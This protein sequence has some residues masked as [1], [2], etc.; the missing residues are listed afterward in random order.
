V[1]GAAECAL[2]SAPAST[3][4]VAHALIALEAGV[5]T[6]PLAL[7]PWDGTK[8]P[9]PAWEKPQSLDS[10]MKSSVLWFYRRTA[11][12][13]GRERM[14]ASLERFGYGS[15]GYE[16][17]QTSFWLNGDLAVSPLEQLDFLSR[18]VTY[19]LPGER[20]SWI[21]GYVESN[22]RSTAFVAR[23]RGGAGLSMQAAAD[24]ALRT[25]N[26]RRPA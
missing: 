2:K 7:V 21:I 15:D 19:K 23:V 20:I 26:A 12:R 22:Q 17:E 16:G 8:Q 3:S 9:Y 6:D 25:L 13:I 1:S 5:V 11:G 10:A 14:V 4:K 24:L 18:L